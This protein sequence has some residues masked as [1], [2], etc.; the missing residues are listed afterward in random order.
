MEKNIKNILITDELVKNKRKE[1]EIDI[2]KI[3]S[4]DENQVLDFFSNYIYWNGIFAGLVTNLSSK[5]HLGLDF[6][7]Y[8]KNSIERGFF[9]SVGHKVA[10]LIFAAAEDEYAD[11]SSKE[12]IRIEHK[13]MAWFMMNKMYQ[14]YGRDISE[15]TIDDLM[16]SI[17]SV[18][19]RGYGLNQD[20]DFLSLVRYL[21]FHIGSEKIAS[22]EFGIIASKMK[23]LH[24]DL[25]NW[26]KNQELINGINAFS[27]IEVHGPVEDAH[28]NYALDAAQMIID[29][30]GNKNLEFQQKVIDELENGFNLFSNLQ[31]SFFKEYIFLKN[32]KKGFLYNE[33]FLNK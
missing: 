8:E 6:F 13:T 24:P 31:D 2:S 12:D 23:E 32:Y 20:S 14:F 29:H 22:Y 26:M 21:G 4:G 17:T 3:L 7:D 30:V 27:W 16:S 1:L 28:A 18:T 11:E 15:R 9:Q 19:K 5:F 10:G 33:K 25:T